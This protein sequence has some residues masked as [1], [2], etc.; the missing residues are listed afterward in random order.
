VY[1]KKLEA[2]GFVRR[3]IDPKDLRRHRLIV[4]SK[5]RK[6]ATPRSRDSV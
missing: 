3:E 6:V 1:S 2:D 4:T 5:G